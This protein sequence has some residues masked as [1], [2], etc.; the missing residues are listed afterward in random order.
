M[1][2]QVGSA[3]WTAEEIQAYRQQGT[4]FIICKKN[5]SSNQTYSSSQIDLRV[6]NLDR[7]GLY[8]IEEN[9]QGFTYFV[10]S[11]YILKPSDSSPDVVYTAYYK[12]YNIMEIV[13]ISER[14]F[15]A[16]FNM[17]LFNTDMSDSLLI[18]AGRIKIDF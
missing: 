13:D 12:G 9:E 4:L 3:L 6:I 11:N 18:T 8:G 2:C 14:H 16:D 1:F 17:I 7:A 15:E 10:K 5:T